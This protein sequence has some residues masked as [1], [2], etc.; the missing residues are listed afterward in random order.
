[1]CCVSHRLCWTRLRNLLFL[2]FGIEGNLSGLQSGPFVAFDVVS[3][4]QQDGEHARGL[5]E[6]PFAVV[7]LRL[8]GPLQERRHVLGQLT[9][10]RWGS[11]RVLNRL[12]VQRLSHADGT[13]REVRIEVLA[14]AQDDASWRIDVARQQSEDVIFAA[15]ASGSDPAEI[16][17]VGA[18]VG[19]ARGFLVR[20]RAGEVIGQLS[21]SHKVLALVVGSVFHLRFLG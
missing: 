12:I 11:V 5:D 3:E 17:R 14:I 13:T 2:G 18:V 10:G 15:M 19:S 16:W 20:V 6:D 21:R 4:R 7:P 1:M 8:R 9:G